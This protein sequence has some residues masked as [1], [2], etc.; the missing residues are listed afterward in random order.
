MRITKILLGLTIVMLALPAAAEEIIVFKSGQTLPIR[1]HTIEDGMVRV[2]LGDNS[3][4]AFPEIAVDRIDRADKNV[5]L[6][7]SYGAAANS[8]IPTTEGSF[9]VQ[10]IRRPSPSDRKPIPTKNTLATPVKTDP[11]TGLA[12][13]FPQGHRSAANRQK[14]QIN[15]NMRVFEQNP[16]RQG[17]GD[18]FSGTT[19]VGGRHILGDPTPRRRR[20]DRSPNIPKMVGLAMKDSNIDPVPPDPGAGSESDDSDNH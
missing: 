2:D 9:P 19:Q 3:M 7:R 18:T 13:Y 14:M 1:S 10:S 16:T 8:Q 12:G 17:T 20:N 5:M 4:M 15:G 11:R 6:K